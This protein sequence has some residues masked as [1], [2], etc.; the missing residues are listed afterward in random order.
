MFWPNLESDQAASAGPNEMPLSVH[1]P[2][3]VSEV[4]RCLDCA[5]GRNYLDL[6]LGGAGHAQAILRKTHPKGSLFACDRD[7][8]A[9][10]RA[11]NKLRPFSGRYHVFHQALSEVEHL[12][13]DIPFADLHGAFID[14]GVSSDQLETAERGF[15]FS[16]TGPLDMRMDKSK[17]ITLREWLAQST[18]REIAD[19]IF[20]Y[21]EER[22]SRKV[23]RAIVEA[24]KWGSLETTQDLEE[25]V[26][27]AFPKHR[28]SRRIHP[29]TRTFQALRIVVND[30]LGELKKGIRSL[31][32][33]MPPSS[34][35]VVL[36]FHS[37]EDRVVK[38]AFRTAAR[39][40]RARLLFKKPLVP[41]DEE[42]RENPRSRST[43]L[44]AIELIGGTG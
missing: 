24:K 20:R 14:S 19:A 10:E 11:K 28:R 39:Q 18:E 35:L 33:L 41:T 9:L 36:T 32:E 30:E 23:A 31:L 44:R 2:V 1:Q 6:T 29:A 8:E 25:A 7:A 38:E 26:F 15:S 17:G 12:K 27:S 13:E 43:K 22:N 34:R 4:L 42:I 3:M 40:G 16:R 21:G 37:L 5:P